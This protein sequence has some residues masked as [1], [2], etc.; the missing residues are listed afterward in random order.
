MRVFYDCEFLEDGRTVDLISIGLVA[1]DGREYYAVSSDAD[2]ERIR[3]HDWLMR[4][5][6]P[7][8][9]ITGRQSIETYLAAS[10]N[11]HPRPSVD[12][13]D[14]DR[15]DS[16]VKPRWVIANEVRDFMQ[17]TP[18]VEL[19]AWYGA[20]DHVALAQLWGPM[21]CLPRGIPMYTN[22]LRSE[23]HRL[24]DPEM[25]EQPAG[26]HNAL[27]DARHNRVRAQFLD[28]LDEAASGG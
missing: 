9:P 12:L 14:V 7:H 13:V 10:P 5:V 27:A 2:W 23:C 6:V 20:Y 18:D 15:T 3:K 11:V 24:G 1:D 28:E 4:N 19:W 26:E 17:S 16:Q 22:D 21:I 25:P 8:L